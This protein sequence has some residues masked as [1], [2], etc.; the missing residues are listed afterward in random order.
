MGRKCDK[1]LKTLP[2]SRS[3]LYYQ[4]A[5]AEAVDHGERNFWC[6]CA[7]SYKV[8]DVLVVH[9]SHLKCKIIVV[10]SLHTR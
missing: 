2:F 3:N 4:Y 9:V 7:E 1:T 5:P 10:I 8:I 6:V